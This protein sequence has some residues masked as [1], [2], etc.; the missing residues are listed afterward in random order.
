MLAPSEDLLNMLT[1]V[2][3]LHLLRCTPQV[4]SICGIAKW[5]TK[6]IKV[7]SNKVKPYILKSA[8]FKLDINER[9][10]FSVFQSRKEDE[11]AGL[12]DI[13]EKIE[14]VVLAAQSLQDVTLKGFLS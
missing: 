2:H 1:C 3:L 6:M 8:S 12:Q 10:C 5:Q 11:T 4:P 7:T 14:E 9:N 13:Y